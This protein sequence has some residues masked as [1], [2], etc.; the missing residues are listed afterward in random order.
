MSAIETSADINTGT[1]AQAS[2]Q[3]PLEVWT[4]FGLNGRRAQLDKHGLDIADR[5]EQSQASRKQ[6][7]SATRALRSSMADGSN[8]PKKEYINLLKAYQMEVDSLT[9]RAKLAETAFLS[10]YKD[11]YEVPDPVEELTRAAAN[12]RRVAE[13]EKANEALEKERGDLAERNTVVSKYEKKIA[14][15]KTEIDTTRTRVSEEIA[16]KLEEKQAQWMAAQQKTMESYNF[17]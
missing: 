15:L 9:N 5:M 14:E 17:V 13:L 4:A 16:A 7:T 1:T 8:V 10:L 6:L 11:L 2:S 12:L 3:S